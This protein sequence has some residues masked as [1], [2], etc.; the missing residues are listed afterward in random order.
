MLWLWLWKKQEA[1][2]GMDAG[3]NVSELGLVETGGLCHGEAGVR[4]Q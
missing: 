3:E 2:P 4:R 1:K